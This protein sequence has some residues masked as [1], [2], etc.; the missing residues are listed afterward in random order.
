M[1]VFLVHFPDQQSGC[2]VLTPLPELMDHDVIA[3]LLQGKMNSVG[4]LDTVLDLSADYPR[5]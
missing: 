2:D 1:P 5:T 4:N 3:S